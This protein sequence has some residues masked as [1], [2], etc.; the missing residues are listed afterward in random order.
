MT[1]KALERI[2]EKVPTWP[3]DLQEE[4]LTVLRLLGQEVEEPYELTPEDIASIE[5][6]IADADAG[7]FATDEEMQGLFNRYRPK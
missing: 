1:T 5:Q 4:A 2:L 6:G 7:R 3:D